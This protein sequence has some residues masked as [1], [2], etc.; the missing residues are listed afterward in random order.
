[1]HLRMAALVGSALI[2]FSLPLPLGAASAQSSPQGRNWAEIAKLPDWSGY[3]MITREG[4]DAAG[5]ETSGKGVPLTPA[6]AKREHDAIA[7]NAQEPLTYCLPAGPIGAMEHGLVH[8]YLFTPGLITVIMEDGEIRRIFT[9]GRA[10]LPLSQLQG[11]YMG[12]S[13]GHWE[14]NVL[15]VDTI[16][17]PNGS[18]FQGGGLTAT[19]NTHLVEHIFKNNH[20]LMEID[21]VVTDPAIFTKPWKFIRTFQRASI[22]L[23][24]PGCRTNLRDTG[25]SIDLTPPEGS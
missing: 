23:G 8:Q 18:L 11:R 19:I 17:F 1:M 3:W 7:S 10:H 2:T 9:D 5:A 4:G 25:D 13:I 24:E 20:G 16:G 21:N 22:E 14:G 15:I 6:Y 12:D